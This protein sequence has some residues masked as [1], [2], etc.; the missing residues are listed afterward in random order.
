[1]IK[2]E[3]HQIFET[4]ALAI[5]GNQKGMYYGSVEWGWKK[6]TS[7]TAPQGIKFRKKSNDFPSPI[8]MEAARLWNVSVTSENKETI[9]LPIGVPVTYKKN[10][11][12][13]DSPDKRKKI[14]DLAKDTRLGRTERLDPKQRVWWTNVIVVRGPHIGKTG[15]L[16]EAD[17]YSLTTGRDLRSRK[18]T[19]T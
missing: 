5:A 4:T 9:D 2:Q 8:F 16:Q 19:P 1:M 17:I 10:T 18:V 12:L 14:A 3:W 7:D 6:S 15:W 11:P 13:W